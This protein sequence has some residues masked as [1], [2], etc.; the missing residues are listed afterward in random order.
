MVNYLKAT[1]EQKEYA[2]M[3]REILEKELKP[4][5]EEYEHANDGLGQYPMEV[6]KKLAEAGFY[7]LNIP[8]EYG[9]M[10][11]DMVTRCVIMEEIAQVDAAFAFDF[12]NGGTFFPEILATKIPEAEKRMWAEKH[13]S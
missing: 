13:L 11:M 5:L 3:V 2:A 10:N 9:G 1:E 4:H 8:E 7:A 12:Y 6:H